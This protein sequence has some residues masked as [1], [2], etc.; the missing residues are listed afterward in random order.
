MAVLPGD[1]NYRELHLEV[2]SFSIEEDWLMGVS[3]IEHEYQTPYKEKIPLYEIAGQKLHYVS[4][5]EDRDSTQPFRTVPWTAEFVGCCRRFVGKA[6]TSP[7]FSIKATVDLSNHVASPRLVLMPFIYINTQGSKLTVCALSAGGQTAR[8]RKNGGTINYTP[9]DNTPATFKWHATASSVSVEETTDSKDGR[10]IMLLLGVLQ[11]QYQWGDRDVLSMQVTMGD[12]MVQGN[13]VIYVKGPDLISAK[14][15]TTEPFGCKSDEIC[16]DQLSFGK[17]FVFDNEAPKIDFEST[18]VPATPLEVRYI[19]A[20]ST[21]QTSLLA[22]RKGAVHYAAKEIDEDHAGLPKGASFAPVLGSAYVTNVKVVFKAD[23]QNTRPGVDQFISSNQ[24]DYTDHFQAGAQWHEVENSNFNCLTPSS[25]VGGAHISVYI[26]K[27]FDNVFN[28]TELAPLAAITGIQLANPS[29]VAD[30]ESKGYQK[31]KENL[32]EQSDRG[33]IYIMY[34]KGSGPPVTDVSATMK[35]GYHMITASTSHSQGKVATATL[36]VSYSSETRVSRGLVWSP[37]TGQDE[38]VIVC[39]TATAWNATIDE[40]TPLVYGTPMQCVLMDVVPTAPPVFFMDK[41]PMYQGYMGKELEIP[42]RF[43]RQ[44]RPLSGSEKVP[45]IRFGIKGD[46]HTQPKDSDRVLDLLTGRTKTGAR[47]MNEDKTAEGLS[48]EGGGVDNANVGLFRGFLLW[49]PS[50]YQGGW[51]GEICLDACVDTSACPAYAGG[52]VEVCSQTCF[53]VKVDRCKWALVPFATPRP[54]IH[55][56]LVLPAAG[57][58]CIRRCFYSANKM[59]MFA[60]RRGFFCRDRATFSD[61]LAAALVLEPYG[62]APGPCQYL[63]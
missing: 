53:H 3:Y 38:E 28:P 60:A 44:D 49:T 23:E 36:Y 43:K 61:E 55:D 35:P 11:P 50:P 25:C 42:L 27:A 10:C 54:T 63:D 45:S 21:S 33:E 8:V 2:T 29:Q 46:A 20:T 14:I 40:N 30:F 39:A 26:E 22:T 58:M 4:S 57:R 5:P 24:R 34:K 19:V 18:A 7:N 32:L 13:Y 62:R 56:C 59:P 51:S 1:G 41:E 6:D 15:T 48:V 47:I 12:A 9:D 16:E 31:L 17:R 37:C 52:P